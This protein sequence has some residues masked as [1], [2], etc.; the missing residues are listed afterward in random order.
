MTLGSF[1]CFSSLLPA[2]ADLSLQLPQ[3]HPSRAC[4]AVVLQ[5]IAVNYQLLGV[6]PSPTQPI[7]LPGRDTA[8]QH[9]KANGRGCQLK[10]DLTQSA[11]STSRGPP[12]GPEHI[13]PARHGRGGDRSIPA[14][15][16]PMGGQSALQRA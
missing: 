3:L 4:L 7:K 12:M 11:P 13:F 10:G 16:T 1:F 14:A 9:D 2:G 6:S 5:E 15:P 8:P